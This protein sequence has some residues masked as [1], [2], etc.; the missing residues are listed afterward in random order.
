MNKKNRETFIHRDSS[1][2]RPV[3]RDNCLDPKVL[4]VLSW[5]EVNLLVTGGGTVFI[6]SFHIISYYS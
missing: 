6:S 1:R 5:L 2:E 4:A 3:Y